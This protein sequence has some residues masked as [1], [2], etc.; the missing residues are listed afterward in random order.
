MKNVATLLAVLAIASCG[1]TTV[2]TEE[3]AYTAESFVEQIDSP[4]ARRDLGEGINVQYP[5]HWYVLG[6]DQ[7]ANIT[8]AGSALSEAAGIEQHGKRTLLAVNATP[9]PTGAMIRV[10]VVSPATISQNELDAILRTGGQDEFLR[11]VHA[12]FEANF[13]AI[14]ARSN[15][16]ISDVLEPQLTSV[17]GRPAVLIRYHRTS[18]VDGAIWE[19]RLY[20]IAADDRTIELTLSNRVAD[21][22]LWT[23]ILDRTRETMFIGP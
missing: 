6:S 22:T 16:I 3:P 4:F 11:T 20:Q 17:S 14:A 9:A 8:A 1:Q 7:S 15:I 18:A 19:V 13:A 5:R 2:T 23:P 10:S 21:R 12:E